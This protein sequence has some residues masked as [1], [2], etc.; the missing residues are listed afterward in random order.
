MS[1][2]TAAE[3]PRVVHALPG[4]VRVHLPG[5]R[6][7][8]R[9]ALEQ[10]VRALEGVHGARADPRTGNILV[11]FDP[12]AADPDS[13]LT[14][15]QSRPAQPAPTS[16]R[17]APRTAAAVGH[18]VREVGRVGRRARIAVPGLDTDPRVAGHAV[19]R[20]RRLPGV[21][22][23]SASQ[24]TGRVLVE[25]SERMVGVEDL[26]AQV[27][28]LDL[29]DVPSEDA[30]SHPLDPAPLI[31]SAA[32]TVGSGLGLGL[33]AGRRAIGRTGPPA[34]ADR[35]AQV[36]GTVGII[37]GLPPI[38]RRLEDLLGRHGAQ[39]ALSG[40]TIVGLAFAGNPLGLAVSGAGALRLLTTVRARRQAWRD[41]EERVGDAEPSHPGERIEV[42][43]GERVPLR[44]HVISGFGTTISRHGEV[45]PI[46]PGVRV[47]AGARL[48]GGPAA[49]ELDGER[50]FVPAVRIAP[51]TPTIYD[52]YLSLLPTA[53]L[54]YA[55]VTGVV[56]RSLGRAMTALLL[57]NPRTALIGAE[58]ADNGAAARVLRHGVTVVGSREKRPISRPDV[59]VIESPRALVS[60]LRLAGVRASGEDPD[61]DA[62]AR[63]AAGIS[64]AAG[65]PWG[66]VFAQTA[67]ADA[68]DGTFDGRI[69][70]AEI[71]GRRWSL[72][73]ARDAEDRSG[74]VLNLRRSGARA[75]A[76]QIDLALAP[77]PGLDRL[78]DTCARQRVTLE[79]AG[80]CSPAMVELAARHELVAVGQDALE[81]IH[82]HQA[83]GAIVAVLS[84]SAHAAPEFAE[85]D[86]AIALSSGRGGRFGARADLLVADLASVATVIETGALRDRAVRDS[87]LASVGANIAGAAWGIAGEPRFERASHAT[88]V[89]ALAGIGD[90][91]IR[92]R[93]G[94]QGRSVTER[95]SDPQ[96]ERFGRQSIDEVLATLDSRPEG[97]TRDETGAR[98]RPE[99]D[100]DRSNPL[101]SAMLDQLRSPLTGI[102]AAAAGASLL[103]GA[104]GDVAMLGAV[105]VVNTAVG[106]WQER[107]AGRAA[108]AL[109]EMSART[110][111]VLRDGSLERVDT[112]ELVPG[113]VIVLGT[114]DRVPAD[115][116]LLESED[117]EVDEAPLTGESLPVEKAAV[118]GTPA[119]RIVLEGSDV[120]V[121]TARAVVVAVG[122]QTRMGATAAA[123]ALQETSESPLGQRLSQMFREG[124][125]LVA[126]G[127]LLVTVAGLLWGR[128]LVPQLALGVSVAVAAIPEG[129][130]LLAGVAQAS[131]ARR[132]TGRDALVRR[133]AAVEALGRVDVACADKTGT[134]TTGRLTLT[135]V[136]DFDQTAPVSDSLPDEL[137]AVLEAGALASPP[138]DGDGSGAHP[139][140]VAVVQGARQAGLTAMEELER[141]AEEPF[142][143]ARGFH[144]TAA[145]GRLYVKGAAEVLAPRCRY[146]RQAGS[147]RELDDA[148][149]AELLARAE[150]LSGEG[151]R[152]LMACEG[153]GE[154]GDPEHPEG[155]VAL[156]YLGISDPLRPGVAEAVGRCEA[157]G[158]RVIML[159]GD[160]PATAIAVAR[161]AGLSVNGGELLTGPELA[162]IDDPELDRRLERAH[163]V[164]RVTPLDK[165]RIVEALQRR[166]HVVAMTGDG[167]NDAPALRLADVGVAMGSRGTDVAREA[168][169]V[170]IAHD[171]FS[172]L[173]EALV[174]GR[175]F[176]HN[177]RRALGLLLGGNAGELGLMVLAGVVGLAPPLSTRQVLAVN[178]VTDILPAVAVAVQEPE[179]R[180]L[181]GLA[182]EGTV[183]L[184]GPL[185][186]DV[187]RRGLATALP[188]FVAYGL[189]R[190]RGGGD[191][192]RAGAVAFTTVVSGQLAQ[193]LELG[194]GSERRSRAVEGAVL[195]SAAFVAAAVALPP[196]QGFFG[197]AIP[198]P[199]GLAL[200]VGGT[201]A[202][203][204]ISR[205]LAGGGGS[206]DRA[207]AGDGDRG[208]A[209]GLLALPA[210]AGT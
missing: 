182:R 161:E 101:L 55:G 134:L 201:I 148:G 40:V 200:C 205:A 109:A 209:A 78:L 178:L 128:P 14:A 26:L 105:I 158:V 97:L 167:V 2:A 202:S 116:R 8:E 27:A 153:S 3:P 130:P 54:V 159:T 1:A 4:R 124:L 65:S 33:L 144:A 180:D 86:L 77:A 88:Y 34:G 196:L 206:N 69:A 37:E 189:A 66:E 207:L 82:H 156:G 203:V 103:L 28:K 41:Y 53:S 52:R 132:L 30:P 102:L 198:G 59:L 190:L 96:P 112:A 51:P 185:R 32:R 64:A 137:R 57:V 80:R 20:L 74:L 186:R 175:T 47:D 123:V 60:G 45:V 79:L 138:P 204:A 13:I 16:A 173:V 171:D 141:A 172:T 187:L 208:R 145:G 48:C 126:G 6:P 85:G 36:A 115:A 184:G 90:G 114:G 61:E 120:T 113:D 155:L 10:R 133:L 136:A 70:S 188:S 170:V 121:G 73:P 194:A 19:T 76:G 7:E 50:P 122:A 166:G 44:G 110:T 168:A 84:D 67:A 160:H 142:D 193:T 111:S 199:F 87:V 154:G 162:S 131:V 42:E 181:A 21:T 29:P 127:G 147:D 39:L 92:L 99:E 197:L 106:T 95:L 9:Q 91:W 143:P 119:S 63:L 83:A 22:R 18:V 100:R 107:Q 5:W 93:G 176:W 165:L 43:A 108:E 25:Y 38:Q 12:A 140:D 151:L 11:Q 174:E 56:T 23:V 72:A 94:R 135:R 117:L 210:P 139:T 98:R 150:A 75:P 31:Q 35:A 152:V 15:L 157:A 192:R 164:A 81:R 125:P 58:S 183:A 49:I 146:L 24:L 177:V 46:A 179:H 89:G 195:G 71:E 129:L 169:D 118:G 163:V 104:V 149:R 62:V 68:F 17:R 191:P